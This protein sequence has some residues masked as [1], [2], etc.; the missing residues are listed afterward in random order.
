MHSEEDIFMYFLL[1]ALAVVAE[2]A[3]VTSG[4]IA[5]AETI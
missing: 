5:L 2:T 3:V 4:F 1:P